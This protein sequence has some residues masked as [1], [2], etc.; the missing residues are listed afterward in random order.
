ETLHGVGR[1]I[2]RPLPLLVVDIDRVGSPLAL[3]QRIG[4]PSLGR[5]VVAADCSRLPEA[6]PQHAFGIRP[7]AAR[8]HARLRWLHHRDGAGRR[9]DLCN[10]VAGQR[11]VPDLAR[12]CRSDAVRT[13]AFGRLPRI[14]PAGSGI[15]A[16]VDPALA[17]EPYDAVLVEGQR[18]E[19]GAGKFLRQREQLDLFALGVDPR[20]GVLPA[21]GQPGI[22]IGPDDH[23]VRR[24]TGPERN[25]LEPAGLGVESAGKS[26]A[27]T[28]EPHRAVRRRR[29]VVRE[30]AGAKLV[31]RHSAVWAQMPGA[32]A[33]AAAAITV[34]IMTFPPRALVAPARDHS[35][36]RAPPA[37]VQRSAKAS[38][39]C[40]AATQTFAPGFASALPANSIRFHTGARVVRESIRRWAA[41][42]GSCR[43]AAAVTTR[44]MS[45]PG[46]SRP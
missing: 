8:P 46:S 15:G 16:P 42:K 17:G 38:S 14:D 4:R 36:A 24:R 7:D 27:L 10:M 18:V 25:L 39:D 37:G 41:A 40:L 3:R 34:R 13:R 6:H 28:A 12:R 11:C 1:P 33:S 2:R 45:S 5:R 32:S 21:F 20:D 29:D 22:A 23:A 30:G 26:L 43:W 44:T 35:A 9:I 19:V 31:E